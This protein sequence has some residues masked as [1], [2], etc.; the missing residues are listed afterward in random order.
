MQLD[1]QGL[2][3]LVRWLLEQLETK[4]DAEA[5]RGLTD[6]NFSEAYRALL[7]GAYSGAA[8]GLVPDG[9]GAAAGTY[10]RVDGAWADAPVIQS[11][12]EEAS[13]NDP[14]FI[15]NK[16]FGRTEWT[17]IPSQTVATDAAGMAMVSGDPGGMPEGGELLVTFD[18]I[19]HTL[20]LD[21]EYTDS[22]ELVRIT[23]GNRYFETG[24]YADDTGEPL[25]IL[26]DAEGIRI[27]SDAGH[28]H[29][30]SAD[31]TLVHTLD[32]QW[33]GIEMDP[34]TT[35]EIDRL[36]AEAADHM[37]GMDG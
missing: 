5:G 32:P 7:D 4:V 14:A 23:A 34:I 16:P 30:L 15:R 17:V 8:P 13:A 26:A 29:T 12:W 22:G 35:T 1:E 31:A 3:I 18:G 6:E 19:S 24:Q 36:F 28:V 9:R 27:L 25:M 10:L 37:E 11:D 21:A 2:R 33:V 20:I